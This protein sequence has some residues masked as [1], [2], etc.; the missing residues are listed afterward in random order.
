VESEG[1]FLILLQ[2]IFSGRKLD[3][4]TELGFPSLLFIME[5]YHFRNRELFN[6]ILVVALLRKNVSLHEGKVNEELIRIRDG[7]NIE[8]KVVQTEAGFF[9]IIK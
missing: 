2:F 8:E 3:S 6:N 5:I 4:L 1:S 9:L 7:N